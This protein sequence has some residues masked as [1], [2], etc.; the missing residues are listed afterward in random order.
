MSITRRGYI[1]AILLAVVAGLTAHMWNP[2]AAPAPRVEVFED[3]SGILHLDGEQIVL[4]DG[5]FAWDCTT[6]G[7]RICG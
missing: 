2:L 3:G 5:T 7:N 4:E 6:M 1:V